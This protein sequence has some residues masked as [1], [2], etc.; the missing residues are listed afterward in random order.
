[1]ANGV[2]ATLSHP[3]NSE[4]MVVSCSIL[5]GQLSIISSITVQAS[6]DRQTDRQREQADRLQAELIEKYFEGVV[7]MRLF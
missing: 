4:I 2:C 5:I 7:L 6:V 1:M 3:C